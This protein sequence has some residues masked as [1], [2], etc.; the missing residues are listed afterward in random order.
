MDARHDRGRR[1][2]WRILQGA[3]ADGDTAARVLRDRRAFRPSPTESQRYQRADVERRTTAGATE[4][5][6]GRRESDS[7]GSRRKGFEQVMTIT[8][9]VLGC[10][11]SLA[12]A[13]SA[14]A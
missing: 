7:R 12:F 6:N 13:Y 11:L 9:L 5:G 10:G 2:L 14:A 8:P 1:L 4:A 3:G